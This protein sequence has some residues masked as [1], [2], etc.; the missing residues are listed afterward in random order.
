MKNLSISRFPLR[1]ET[2]SWP[3]VPNQHKIIWLET[4]FRSGARIRFCSARAP[5][6]Y[7]DCELNPP[8][9]GCNGVATALSPCHCCN[10][11]LP[12]D[13]QHSL[14]EGTCIIAAGIPTECIYPRELN[15]RTR[16]NVSSQLGESNFSFNVSFFGIFFTILTFFFYLEYRLFCCFFFFQPTD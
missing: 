11:S 13:K 8:P 10:R 16:G 1:W 15:H 2:H 9:S 6:I 12:C 3:F 7:R 14:W 4:F 5:N